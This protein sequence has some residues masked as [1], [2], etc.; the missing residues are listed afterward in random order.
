MASTSP[1]DLH[2]R[3]A[4][5]LDS[6]DLDALVALY[7]P[8]A[9]LV[10]RP[11][12]SVQGPAAITATFAAILSLKPTFTMETGTVLESDGVALLH[13]TWRLVGTGSDGRRVE[14]SG[15]GADVARR[16]SDGTWLLAVD[17]AYAADG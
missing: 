10:T 14:R 3:L 2:Q 11:G 17:N 13:S 16:Q 15:R 7:E 4:A 5:A 6:H 12:R 8:D 9:C 1:A